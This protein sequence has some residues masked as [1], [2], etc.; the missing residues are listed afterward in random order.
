MC[1]NKFRDISDF[2]GDYSRTVLS[3]PEYE[4]SRDEYFIID[5]HMF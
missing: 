3:L 5:E 1:G 2:V 4:L